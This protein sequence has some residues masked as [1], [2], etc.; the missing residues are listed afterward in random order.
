MGSNG[1]GLSVHNAVVLNNDCVSHCVVSA[2][3]DIFLTQD[4]FLKFL[5]HPE[6]ARL[7]LADAACPNSLPGQELYGRYSETL[8]SPF[9]TPSTEG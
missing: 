1:S 5:I 9:E 2:D 7:W 8:V 3:T 6:A 4:F